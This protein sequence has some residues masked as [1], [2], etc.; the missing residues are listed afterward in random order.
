MVQFVAPQLSFGE[1]LFGGIGEGL[2][3]GAEASRQQIMQEQSLGRQQEMQEKA[4]KRQGEEYL[5]FVNSEEYLNLPLDQ[6]IGLTSTLFPQVEKAQL[7]REKL[8]QRQ[9][10]GGLGGQAVPSEISQTM[11]KVIKENPDISASDLELL[12]DKAGVPRGFSASYVKNL[13]EEQKESGRAK[14]KKQEL[15]R[16]EKLDIHKESKTYDTGVTK[17][18][19]SAERKI[20]AINRQKQIQPNISNWDRYIAAT[21]AGTRFEDLMKSQSA[22]EFDSLVLPMIEGQ[23]ENF[24]VRLSDADLRLVLQ[25]MATSTKHP[26]ANKKI[27]EWQLLES[28][29]DVERAKIGREV[30]KENEGFRPLD[31]EDQVSERM[32][33]KF[34]EEIQNKFDDVMA[35]EDNPEALEKFV[36]KKV[37]PGTPL[38]GEVIDMY[39]KMANDDA[40]EARSLAIEDGYVL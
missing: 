23:K 35:L 17:K 11:D 20:K 26:A 40:Q 33:Q 18:A 36:R 2:Q 22:Q 31:Y 24:G 5:R 27:M 12:F 30:K 19:E 39:L 15:A 1:R 34:G 16:K 38:T 37:E 3:R 29:L 21:F 9:P 32:N 8:S 25:K 14:I 28:R 10:L 7:E 6:K 13:R 4:L